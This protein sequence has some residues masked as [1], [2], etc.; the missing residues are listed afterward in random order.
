LAYEHPTPGRLTNDSGYSSLPT[1]QAADGNG[2]GRLNSP[3][4]AVTLPGT[5]YEEFS[6]PLNLIRATEGEK[7]GPNQRGSKGDLLPTPT[8][9]DT[10]G[11]GEHGDGAPDLRTAVRLLPPPVVIE[12]ENTRLAGESTPPQSIGGNG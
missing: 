7:G 6:K 11:A 4:H 8:T 3:G 5:I 2:G 1:P 9:S 10:N 12:P